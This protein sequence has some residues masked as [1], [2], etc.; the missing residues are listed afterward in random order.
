MDKKSV[1]YVHAIWQPRY[2]Q[3]DKPGRRGKKV[4]RGLAWRRGHLYYMCSRV[5]QKKGKGQRQEI[6]VVCARLLLPWAEKIEQSASWS[7]VKGFFL[8]RQ[9]H[10]RSFSM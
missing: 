2:L 9:M 8:G 3:T 1:M 10:H 7:V 5:R 6:A 4:Q